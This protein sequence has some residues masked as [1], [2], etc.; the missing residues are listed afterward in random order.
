MNAA[1][2]DQLRVWDEVQTA[3]REAHA[4]LLDAIRNEH[5]RFLSICT[6]MTEEQRTLL[7]TGLEDVKSS[8]ERVRFHCW[9]IPCCAACA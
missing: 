8:R 1:V 7:E 5:Q 2:L 6:S 3:L 9:H 4:E